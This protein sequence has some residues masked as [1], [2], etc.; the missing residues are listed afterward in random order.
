[1]TCTAV[2]THKKRVMK[3]LKTTVKVTREVG[4]ETQLDSSKLASLESFVVVSE[5]LGSS[6][7]RACFERS[8]IVTTCARSRHGKLAWE[9]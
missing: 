3:Q 5:L 9:L 1:M 7:V 6:I 8:N 4:P 2:Q